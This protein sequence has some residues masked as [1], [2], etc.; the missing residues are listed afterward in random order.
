MLARLFLL[1]WWLLEFQLDWELLAH[2]GHLISINF[3]LDVSIIQM[4]YQR[5]DQT[6]LQ[7][8]GQEWNENT[9]YLE[10]VHLVVSAC[11]STLKSCPDT[12]FKSRSLVANLIF[13]GHLFLLLRF[14]FL[15]IIFSILL[16][17][18]ALFSLRLLFWLF[19]LILA[20]ILAL[21]HALILCFLS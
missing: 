12:A 16:W 18:L 1:C 5:T 11:L 15:F 19:L 3:L 7:V 6:Q 9:V 4:L 8:F 20:F 14:L 13:F 17:L 21:I 10:L 2:I